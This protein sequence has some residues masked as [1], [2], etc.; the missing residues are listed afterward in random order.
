M[1][2]TM[3]NKAII[4]LMGIFLA[5]LAVASPAQESGGVFAPYVSRLR[6]GVKDDLIILTWEDSPDSSGGLLVYRAPNPITSANLP[7]A[8][9]VGKVPY[10][11]GRFEDRPGSQSEWYYAVLSLDESGAP[12]EF[13]LPFKNATAVGVHPESPSLAALPSDAESFVDARFLTAKVESDAVVLKFGVSPSGHRLVFYRSPDPISSS[14]AVLSASIVTIVDDTVGEVR[15][16]PVPGIGYYYAVIDEKR[17]KEG[18]VYIQPGA[19]ATLSPAKVEAGAFRVGLPEVS[20]LSRSIPL[21]FRIIDNAIGSGERLGT[22]YEAPSSDPSSPDVEKA[23]DRILKLLPT[24]N[25]NAPSLVL[26]ERDASSPGTGEDYTLA[27]I[28][29]ECIVKSDWTNAISQLEKFLSLRR[30]EST[31]RRARFYLGQAYALNGNFRDALFSLLVAQERYYL[32]TRDWIA[33]CLDELH[34]GRDS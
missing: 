26:V 24:R 33:Y 6:I 10:G 4:A 14:L 2:G 28:V 1:E 13:F 15:D 9:M 7:S 11:Q 34:S 5:F 12:Y 29:N 30:A 19:N 18:G 31:E 32:E 3:R 22:A 21:P 17:L 25:V 23:I 27:S 8:A 16:Y 20:P